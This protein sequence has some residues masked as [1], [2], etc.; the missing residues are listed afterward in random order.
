MQ[1]QKSKTYA[2]ESKEASSTNGAAVTWAQHVQLQTQFDHISDTFASSSNGT[3]IGDMQVKISRNEDG[4]T[5]L[6]QSG[7]KQA[8]ICFNVY[9]QNRKIIMYMKRNCD[10]KSLY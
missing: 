7:S 5:V 4:L 2:S 8:Q 3:D 9:L 1:R 10:V 6:K